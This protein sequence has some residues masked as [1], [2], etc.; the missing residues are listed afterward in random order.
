[1][2]K[3]QNVK[4]PAVGIIPARYSST[5]FPGKPLA[6]IARKPMIQWVYERSIQAKLL[7]QVIVATDDYRIYN[8]VRAFGGLV[9]MTDADHNSGTDRV[10]QVARSLDADIIINIQGDEPLIEP[11]GIDTLVQLLLDHPECQMATLARPVAH[12]EE[13]TNP[14]TARVLIDRNGDALY[15]TRAAVPF[16]R[17]GGPMAGWLQHAPFYNHIGIYG[18][19]KQFLSEFTSWPSLVYEKTEKLEQLRALEYGYRIKVGIV[20]F[21]PV[22]VDVPTDLE[23]VEQKIKSMGIEI[24]G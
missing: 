16:V 21:E 20:D 1:M 17:D 9:Q 22:C 3:K 10:A 18:Y 11:S 19:R 5:R 23:I 2:K 15:F 6:R 4:K 7:D 14:N 13:L 8:A 12:A 24:D